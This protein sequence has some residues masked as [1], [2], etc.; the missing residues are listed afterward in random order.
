MPNEAGWRFYHVGLIVTGKGERGFLPSLFRSL[1]QTGRC[2]FEVVAR[3]GQRTPFTPGSKR[4]LKMLGSNK[5]IPDKDAEEI[6]VPARRHL[7]RHGEAGL[8]VLIDDLEHDRVDRAHEVFQRYRD[9]LDR[10]LLTDRARASVH[11]LVNM[12]EAYYFAHADAINAVL[13]TALTDHPG[14]DE[15][16][17]HPKNALK[18]LFK[19][20][21]E[22]AHGEQ[23]VKQLDVDHVLSIPT[24]CGSLRA[25]F[26]WCAKSIDADVGEQYQLEEGIYS[27][28]TGPQLATI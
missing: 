23:I 15:E 19:G 12:I 16:I 21:D 24:S 18:A 9:A 13:G 5:L 6:G 8:I 17:R 10:M 1:T 2:T 14:D 3:V 7:K 20:F 26:A 25:L 11:F 28:V 22:I 27:V 4:D